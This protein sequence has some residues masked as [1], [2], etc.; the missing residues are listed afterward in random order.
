MKDIVESISI[1]SHIATQIKLLVE[2]TKATYSNSENIDHNVKLEGWYSEYKYSV[3]VQ[4]IALNNIS[5]F[6]NSYL[7]ELYSELNPIKY[8]H[9]KIEILNFLK[10]VNPA[11]KRIKKWTDLKSFRNQILVHN[12]RVKGISIFASGHKFKHYNVPHRDQEILLL[13]DLICLV[14]IQLGTFFSNETNQVILGKEKITDKYTVEQ[15]EINYRE[16]IKSI[17][18]LVEA[19]KE[20]IL[21]KK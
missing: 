7:D 15:N 12:Y 21:G 2:V 8:P 14:N 13:A 20:K 3:A 10:C 18:F 11:L 4:A 9:Y 19:I 5:I 16:E 6:A 1:L 17:T